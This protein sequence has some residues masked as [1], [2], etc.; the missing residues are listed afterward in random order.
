MTVMGHVGMEAEL[1]EALHC[2]ALK[3]KEK[4]GIKIK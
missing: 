2:T 1:P 3:R 4:K